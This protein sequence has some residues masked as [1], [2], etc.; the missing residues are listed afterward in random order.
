MSDKKISEAV[1]ILYKGGK[2]LSYHC[3]DCS[4]PL[5]EKDGKIFCPSCGREAIFESDLKEGD[6]ANNPHQDSQVIHEET[7]HGIHLISGKESSDKTETDR[8]F[9]HRDDAVSYPSSEYK[10]LHV[11]IEIAA[12]RIC[13]MISRAENAKEVRELTESLDRI[14]EI[15]KKLNR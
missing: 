8:R 4:M 13:D 7:N 10:R 3:P 14:V 9:D 5:F 6:F 15:M 1:E 11:K 12:E 2:M